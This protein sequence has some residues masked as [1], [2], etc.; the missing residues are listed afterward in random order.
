MRRILNT[1]KPYS[2]LMY[3]VCGL[4]S[5][6]FGLYLFVINYLSL[7]L[8]HGLNQACVDFFGSPWL[9]FVMAFFSILS[10]SKFLSFGFN[11]MR[12]FVD[13][14]QSDNVNS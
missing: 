13:V 9:M 11:A 1:I 7:R 6:A 12:E 4:I 5:F 2:F 8:N 10:G 14:N 3:F